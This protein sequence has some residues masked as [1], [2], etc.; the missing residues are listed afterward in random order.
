[1]NNP[2]AQTSYTLFHVILALYILIANGNSALNGSNI[3]D[4]NVTDT[5]IVLM[6]VS[7]G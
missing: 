6:E 2:E 4:S 1:L 5:P 7:L 3:D